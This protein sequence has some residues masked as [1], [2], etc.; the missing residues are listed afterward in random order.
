MSASDV[1]FTIWVANVN[2]C[3]F[4]WWS[5]MCITAAVKSNKKNNKQPPKDSIPIEVIEKEV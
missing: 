3:L 4:V 5:T 1:Q 2:A